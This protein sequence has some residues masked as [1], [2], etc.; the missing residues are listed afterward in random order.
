MN[1]HPTLAKKNVGNLS[2]VVTEEDLHE[3]FGFKTTS[4]LQKTWKAE[5]SVCPKMGM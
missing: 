4:Y 3:L 2:H 1:N 5:L